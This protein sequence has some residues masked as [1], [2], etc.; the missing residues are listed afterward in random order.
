[1]LKRI[2]PQPVC[3]DWVVGTIF[4]VSTQP[5]WLQRMHLSDFCKPLGSLSISPLGPWRCTV[6][7]RCVFSWKGRG[8]W[9]ST[10]E[11]LCWDW[12]QDLGRVL[13]SGKGRLWLWTMTLGSWLCKLAAQCSSVVLNC[14]PLFRESGCLGVFL[15]TSKQIHVFLNYGEACLCLTPWKEQNS[16]RSLACLLWMF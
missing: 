12:D 16:L 13:L 8:Q 1:M 9:C 6:L 3:L 4:E 5:F 14:I 7:M 10:L 15:K 11:H 2:V